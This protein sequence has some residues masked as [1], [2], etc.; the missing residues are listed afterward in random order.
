M[1]PHS[2]G[3]NLAKP[4]LLSKMQN[5][6]LKEA[7]SGFQNICLN[8]GS[9]RLQEIL[10]QPS[11]RQ[12]TGCPK[13]TS[14]HC[15]STQRGL[16]SARHIRAAALCSSTYLSHPSPQSDTLTPWGIQREKQHGHPSLIQ[17][18]TATG[19]NSWGD[20]L[21]AWPCRTEMD[22]QM[23]SYQGLN[24]TSKDFGNTKQLTL[25]SFTG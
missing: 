1:F 9:Q 17:G 11:T 21:S 24:G 25:L 14:H 18:T 6:S 2:T 19:R 10:L 20:S 12:L 16:K 22:E 5:L 8:A 7:P 23:W 13:A 4:T 15:T 3:C